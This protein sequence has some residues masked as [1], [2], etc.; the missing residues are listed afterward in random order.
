MSIARTPREAFLNEINALKARIS[1]LEAKPIQLP[2]VD[3]DPPAGFKGNVVF[4]ADGR[5]HIVTPDGTIWEFTGTS[6]T[7]ASSGTPQPTVPPQPVT[8]TD[9]WDAQWTQAYRASGGLTGGD[10]RFLYYGNSH[11]DSGFNGNQTSL[12]G[13]DYTAI[14]TALA[15]ARVD[16]VTIQFYNVHTYPT[17]GTMV[18]FGLHTNATKPGSLGGIT[19]SRVSAD[20]VL[21]NSEVEHTIATSFGAALRDGIAKGIALQA[22]SDS[23]SYYGYAAGIGSGKDLPRLRITYTK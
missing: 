10:S 3:A 23:Q 15:G 2:M 7:G 9:F 20:R 19:A 22:I 14:Q 11:E 12:I 17:G 4:F 21:R 13:F 5:M 16:G 18:G 8:R 6:S 1:V